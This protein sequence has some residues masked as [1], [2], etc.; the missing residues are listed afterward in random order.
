VKT[1]GLIFAALLLTFALSCSKSDKPKTQ[2]QMI[3]ENAKKIYPKYLALERREQQIASTVWAKE[4]TAQRCGEV[5][6]DFWDK[7][8]RTADKWAIVSQFAVPQI[9]LPQ[10][11]SP[12]NLPHSIQIL[13]PSNAG[14]KLSGGEWQRWVEL[15]RA[16]GWQIGKVEFR[17]TRFDPAS[18]PRSEFYVCFE[19]S[20]ATTNETAMVEGTLRVTWEPLTATSEAPRVSEI[21]ASQLSVRGRK[22]ESPFTLVFDEKIPEREKTRFID[23]LIVYD[24]DGDG[25]SEIILAA[26]NVVYRFDNWKFKAETLCAT[27]PGRIHTAQI[28]DFSNDGFADFLCV[29]SDGLYLHEGSEGG[30]FEKPPR[31]VW[32]DQAKIRYA[33][34]MT[35]GDIDHDGDLDVLLTQYKVPYLLG[36]IPTPYH[37]ANDGHPSY[38]LRNDGAGNFTDVTTEAGLAAKRQRRTYSASFADLD[39]DN[40]LDLAVISDF[41]GV[42]LYRNDG[43]GRFTDVTREWAGEPYAAGMAHAIAD[44]NRDGKQ[45]LLAMGMGSPTVDRLEGMNLKRNDSRIDESKRAKLMFGNR[46]LIAKPNGGFAQT[47][48]SD[49]IARS[50]WSWGCSAFDFDND[51]F[52]DVYVANGHETKESVR[53]FE[54]Q[55]WLHDLY[56]GNSVEDELNLTYFMAKMGATRGRGYSYGGWERNRLFWNQRGDRFIDIA[57]LFGLSLQQDCW[58]VVSGDL[59]GDGLTDV[60]LTT[61]EVWPESK[62]TLKIFRN[63]L[64][65][66]GKW[67]GFRLRGAKGVSAVGARV[68]LQSDLGTTTRQIVT[69]DSF[70]SQ[71]PDTVHFGLGQDAKVDHVRV[72]WPNGQR[73]ELREPTIN[74]YHDVAPPK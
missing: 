70:R 72:D 11:Q 2:E 16:A 40:H 12:T 53:D 24:L 22:G 55:Y 39:N 42:D 45:D 68:T 44:F 58:N 26:K 3:E 23:P 43:T 54:S 73:V 30:K 71:H 48:L 9:V 51:G 36:Q 50:G 19:L 60:L 4:K 17:H 34:V 5:F 67:I 52:L 37:D 61:F 10:L 35:C 14:R 13:S 41:A 57:P 38:L 29:K 59:D 7:L 31:L 15:T 6:D 25:V 64:G 62:Q 27:D 28:A 46:L 8:N 18:R 74:R 63:Q 1:N 20:N 49:S 56:V 21:D 33:L 65:S 66:A 32:S 47:A 69:G